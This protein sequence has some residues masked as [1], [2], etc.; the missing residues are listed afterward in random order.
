MKT[1]TVNT[2]GPWFHPHCARFGLLQSLDARIRV[3]WPAWG[4]FYDEI[5]L[6][7][8]RLCALP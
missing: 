1:C 6:G 7:A 3:R 2:T 4:E 5:H 8:P